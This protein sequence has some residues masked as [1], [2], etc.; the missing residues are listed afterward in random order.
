MT[1]NTFTT[2]EKRNLKNIEKVS[3]EMRKKRCNL[4]CQPTV[5]I[6]PSIKPH[7]ER[8]ST[9]DNRFH[10]SLNNSTVDVNRH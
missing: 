2:A 1:S 5:P 9:V 7:H 10:K 4:S 3:K 8:I 6:P